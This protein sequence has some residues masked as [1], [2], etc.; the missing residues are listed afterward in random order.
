MRD[1]II[2]IEWSKPLLLEEV[3]TGEAS[4]TQG[5]YYITRVFGGK[6]T[7]LYLGIATK[8]NTI[9]NRLRAHSSNWANLYRGVKY[10]R[11]GRI[12]YP[13]VY[14]EEV[15]DHAESA[16]LF[17]PEHERIFPE[18]VSK[19]KSYT[20]QNLYRVENEGDIFEL[21]PVVRMH[22]Q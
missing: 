13:R 18:N 17:A 3:I 19:R 6:E 10:V 9:R 22:E 4:N 14:D 7:S 21:S 1:R 20:Y 16:L 5:L 8:G 12:T 15:I 2:R 11:I